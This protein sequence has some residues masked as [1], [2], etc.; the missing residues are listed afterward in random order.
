V[1]LKTIPIF[2]AF[3]VMGVAD[4]MGPMSD[5]VAKDYKISNVMATL[6]SFFVFIAFAVF[7]VP[8]GLL[9]ARI[10]KKNLL[11]LGLALNACATLVPSIMPPTFPLLLG[12][13]FVLGVGTAF[14]QVAGNPI[15]RDVSA[16]G[17]YSRN[18]SFAQG[19]KG[20]GSSSS[21]Y[22]VSMVSMISVLSALSAMGW[23]GSF[24]IFCALMVLTLVLVA[25]LKI[26][27]TKPDVPPSLASS[28][29]LLKEPIFLLAVIGI[30]AY[31]GAEAS[32]GRFLLPMLEVIGLPA[33]TASK[34]GPGMFFLLLTIGRLV[35]GAILTVLSAR[36][37]FRLSAL[38][39]LL[40][41]AAL[42]SG[43]KS[44]AIPG[45]IA[46]GLGF[47]NIWPLLFSLTVEERPDRAS[48]LSGLMCMA[49]SGGAIVPIA[50][51]RL[52]DLD[53]KAWSF[54]VPTICFAY[55]LLLSLRGGRKTA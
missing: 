18:L 16:A 45:V 41:G 9:A 54:I 49:I 39:G 8:G 1:R 24:P 10:G 17:A 21:S 7:S 42:M 38:L 51:S 48:E 32:M 25:T 30:F 43:A 35:G 11:V 55:L 29:G 33:K 37:F 13:I 22:L 6:L 44:L 3:F 2:F 26:E 34:F 14:L 5:A 12:C 28:L 53:F 36:A 23:R 40:G 4:A 20:L 47:A 27:E 52:V 19:I 50:M 46:A 15:M 31:V